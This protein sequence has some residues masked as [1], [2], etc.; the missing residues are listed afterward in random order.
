MN[1]QDWIKGINEANT[2]YFNAR[3]ERNEILEKFKV[4]F[5]NFLEGYWNINPDISYN[6]DGDIIIVKVPFDYD[7][8]FVFDS[9][10]FHILGW[11]FIIN[12]LPSKEYG[13][14]IVFEFHPNFG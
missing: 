3:D 1:L 9:E 5:A 11:N 2:N 13:W 8:P 6:D 10:V 4:V 7:D 14:W 12:K